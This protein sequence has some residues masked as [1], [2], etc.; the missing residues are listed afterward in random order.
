MTRQGSPG[1]DGEW[2]QCAATRACCR[3]GF[4]AWQR[5][6]RHQCSW[7]QLP[8]SLRRRPRRRRRGPAQ[9]RALIGYHGSSSPRASPTGATWALRRRPRAAASRGRNRENVARTRRSLSE[10]RWTS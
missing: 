9:A 10:R 2:H 6:R 5:G 3:G 4:A 1:D 8:S 7:P